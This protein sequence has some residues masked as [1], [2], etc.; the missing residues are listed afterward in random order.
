MCHFVVTVAFLRAPRLL[1]CNRFFSNNFFSDCSVFLPLEGKPGVG[2][3][4]HL[5]ATFEASWSFLNGRFSENNVELKEE[6][7]NP[8][9]LSDGLTRGPLT[10]AWFL[11]VQSH[12]RE[13]E[14]E[15]T[16]FLVRK[17]P[18]ADWQDYLKH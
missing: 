10:L 11:I 3:T 5:W 14:G 15:V 9:L 16:F 18:L 4:P 8:V 2:S 13:L 6:L 17:F 1:H 7:Q 12:F